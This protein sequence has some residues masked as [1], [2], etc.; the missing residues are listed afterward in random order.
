MQRMLAM[1]A[2]ET[3]EKEAIKKLLTMQ[4]EYESNKLASIFRLELVRK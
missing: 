3:S 2:D 1:I 4:R